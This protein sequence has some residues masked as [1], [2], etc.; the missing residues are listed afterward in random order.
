[1]Y[2]VSDLARESVE[3]GRGDEVFDN[4]K[5]ASHQAFDLGRAA[6]ERLEQQTVIP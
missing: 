1:M 4:V 3:Q 5:D 6:V 2:E